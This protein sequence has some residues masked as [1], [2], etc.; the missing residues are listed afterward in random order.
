MGSGERNGV[1]EVNPGQVN[2]GKSECDICMDEKLALYK[3][4]PDRLKEGLMTNFESS[5]AAAK[6]VCSKPCKK[7]DKQRNKEEG[8]KKNEGE[9]K[10]RSH[11]GK[12]LNGEQT[13][14]V[15]RSS[16]CYGCV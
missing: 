15:H 13:F 9:E 4:E 14:K 2:T 16:P 11:N 12:I 7:R 5:Q 3:R 10:K 6:F 1:R 8:R